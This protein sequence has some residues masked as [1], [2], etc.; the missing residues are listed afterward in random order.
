MLN[1]LQIFMD[2][3]LGCDYHIGLKERNYFSRVIAS[4]IVQIIVEVYYSKHTLCSL[5]SL[6]LLYSVLKLYQQSLKYFV[7]S[8]LLIPVVL[9]LVL[10][11]NK[12]IRRKK[13]NENPNEL[14]SVA[15]QQHLCRRSLKN[16][17]KSRSY[18]KVL[19]SDE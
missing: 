11:S 5:I 17:Q 6:F 3:Y 12:S 9:V 13:S 2:F 18:G 15:I 4:G 8:L 7:W 19:I 1:E 10:M 16:N 14:V